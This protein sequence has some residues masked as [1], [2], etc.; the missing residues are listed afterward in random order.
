MSAAWTLAWRELRSMF[1]SP[2]AY[3]LLAVYLFL[4]SMF[5][6]ATLQRFAV[7]SKLLSAQA[8]ENPQLMSALNL[9][10]AVV[11]PHLWILCMLLMFLIPFLTMRLLSEERRTGTAELILTAPI[12]SESLVMGKFLAGLGFLG[13]AILLS[14]Q[15]PLF[16][17][18]V[19]DPDLAPMAVGFLGLFLAGGCFIAVGLFAS[20]LTDNPVVAAVLAFGLLLGFFFLSV[21]GQGASAEVQSLLSHLSF[22]PHFQQL[23]KGVLAASN[24]FFLVSATA[25]ALFATL[26]VVDSQRWR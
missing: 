24:V 15:Y 1:L 22:A 8:E 20:S 9:N 6:V 3:V 4:G 14:L 10:Q 5:Y 19:G 18:A 17:W 11:R 13:V 7:M 2:M 26:R 12:R 16:L 25:L 21:A 23:A